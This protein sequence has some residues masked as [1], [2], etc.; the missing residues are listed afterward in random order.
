MVCTQFQSESK[1][2]FYFCVTLKQSPDL[3]EK[4]GSNIS[5]AGCGIAHKVGMRDTRNVE[6]GIRDEK[7]WRD[8]DALILIGGTRDS[9]EIDGGMRDLNSK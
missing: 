3:Y 6:G 5:L 4:R 7:S 2:Q 8:R 9:I 1:Q